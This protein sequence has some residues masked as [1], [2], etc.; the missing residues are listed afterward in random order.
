M[1]RNGY[2]WDVDKRVNDV[3]DVPYYGEEAVF[4]N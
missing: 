1:E 2:Y 3:Y 4:L